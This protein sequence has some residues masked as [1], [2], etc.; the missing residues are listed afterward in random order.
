VTLSA[1]F[2]KARVPALRSVLLG[3]DDP[4]GPPKGDD[5]NYAEARVGTIVPAAY[6]VDLAE[7]SE[8]EVLTR[9]LLALR[10]SAAALDDLW[11]R[12]AIEK[13]GSVAMAVAEASHSVHRALSS[14]ADAMT[15]FLRATQS[16]QAP[17]PDPSLESWW[18]LGG[19]LQ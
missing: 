18:S 3:R 5:A 4:A 9:T 8:I 10:G 17:G 7:S 13:Q 15:P 11:A 19:E 12:V 16:P 2:A 14:L 1:Y 6:R